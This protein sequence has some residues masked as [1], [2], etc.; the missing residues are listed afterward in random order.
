MVDSDSCTCF[1]NP[2]MAQML[3]TT[4]Q[5]MMWRP[6]FDY[7]DPEDHERALLLLNRRRKGLREK[8]EFKFRRSDGTY[9]WAAVAANPVCDQNGNYVSSLR[10]VSD[11]TTR[12]ETEELLSRSQE[13]LRAL[14]ARLESA[15][16]EE[17]VRIARE[18]HDE[19]GQNLTAIKMDLTWMKKNAVD[20]QPQLHEKIDAVLKLL[21]A[22]VTSV[23]RICSELRPSALD[24]IGLTAAIESYALKFQARSGIRCSLALTP[25]VLPL[26]SSQ[27]TA[28]FRICQEILTNVAKH[29]RARRISIS[30]QSVNGSAMLIVQDNGKGFSE[31]AVSE[32]QTLGLLGMR[33][34]ARACG[35]SV[36]IQSALKKGTTVT[37]QI[38]LPVTPT[39]ES[40]GQSE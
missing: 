3:G 29:A 25:D 34:R 23:R 10:M 2:K 33:E 28:L 40:R 35:G 26:E 6:M 22:T 7:V 15:R 36:A 21:S 18:I 38:P 39:S 37:V 12:K 19:L 13:N 1:V 9:L 8:Y 30:L 5:A 16:E 4:V 31:L 11:I 24:D 20:D 14:T 17:S 32:R 27:S